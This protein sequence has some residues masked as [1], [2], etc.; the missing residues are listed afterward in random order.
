M[1][2]LIAKLVF[3]FANLLDAITSVRGIRRGHKELGPVMGKIIGARPS[4]LSM[5]IYKAAICSLMVIFI[6][7]PAWGWLVMSS[8]FFYLAWRNHRVP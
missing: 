6:P 1:A 7:A 5:L 3:L 2:I 8:I 4:M